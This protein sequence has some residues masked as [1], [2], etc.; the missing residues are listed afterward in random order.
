MHVAIVTNQWAASMDPPSSPQDGIKPFPPFHMKATGKILAPLQLEGQKLASYFLKVAKQMDFRKTK[1]SSN[2][3]PLSVDAAGWAECISMLFVGTG[4]CSVDVG[5]DEDW[6]AAD[7]C[8]FMLNGNLVLYVILFGHRW[9]VATG[10]L[11]I[12]WI[13]SSLCF[14]LSSNGWVCCGIY[15]SLFW[16]MCFT[17]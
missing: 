5:C 3:L 14:Y 17:V 7:V 9:G 12:L 10:P 1:S 16:L 4:K 8:V 2:L 15:L 11:A 13:K 6:E